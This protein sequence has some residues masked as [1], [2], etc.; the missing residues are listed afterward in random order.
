[1]KTFVWITGFPR[2]GTSWLFRQLRRAEEADWTPEE[3]GLQHCW[4]MM[5]I[6]KERQQEFGDQRLDAILNEFYSTQHSQIIEDV[7]M[8]GTYIHKAMATIPCRFLDMMTRPKA[9]LDC[10]VSK[11][12][13]MGVNEAWPR[14]Y[15]RRS[16]FWDRFF[17]F[18]CRR[19]WQETYA[20]ALKKWPWWKEKFGPT[21][22]ERHNAY[23]AEAAKQEN[24]HIVDHSEMELNPFETV[25]GIYD[26]LG[27]NGPTK[28]GSFVVNT[29]KEK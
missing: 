5:E 15:I 6:A 10:W 16:H 29:R 1:M 4:R 20:S 17:V 28:I 26:L 21:F 7:F 8:A 2:S 18:C 24:W 13:A 25:K 3:Q 11:C 22:E 27:W 19:E 23:Y 14:D 12:P 9:S